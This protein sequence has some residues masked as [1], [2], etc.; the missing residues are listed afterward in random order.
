MSAVLREPLAPVRLPALAEQRPAMQGRVGRHAVLADQRRARDRHQGFVEQV[1]G[2]HA[3]PASGTH[4]QC[5][6]DLRGALEIDQPLRGQQVE[7]QLRM[8]GEEASQPRHQ[9]G[10]GHRRHHADGQDVVAA[11]RERAQLLGQRIQ[12]RTDAREQAFAVGGQAHAARAAHEQAP[13]QAF[14]ERADLVAQGADGEVQRLRRASQVAA[15][16]G[17]RETEQGVQWQALHGGQP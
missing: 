14:L 5:G 1:F 3:R 2:G 13:A 17:G 16:R 4:A 12:V 8:R 11:R 7:F 6:I 10:R 15:A 9:P